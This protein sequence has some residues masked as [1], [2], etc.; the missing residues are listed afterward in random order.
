MFGTIFE[1]I[2]IASLAMLCWLKVISITDAARL[3]WPLAPGERVIPG[4]F[5]PS[6]RFVIGVLMWLPLGAILTGLYVWLVESGHITYY[7][8][9]SAYLFSF[10]LWVLV[11]CLI[12]PLTG[13]GLFG[14]KISTWMWLESFFGWLIF[15]VVFGLLMR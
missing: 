9:G 3:S 15:A 10:G 2:L 5:K 6:V 4:E 12:F 14:M 7:D 13:S 11:N 1:Y 8:F